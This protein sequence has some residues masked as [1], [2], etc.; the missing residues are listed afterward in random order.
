MNTHPSTLPSWT[1]AY[2]FLNYSFCLGM[3]P[4]VGMLDHMAT[5]LLIFWGT[6]IVFCIP[7]NSVGGFHFSPYPLQNLSVCNDGLSDCSEVVSHCSFY[8]H[9]PNHWASQVVLVEPTCQ[10]RRHKRH[11]FDPWVRK[12]PW[13]RVMLSIV[14]CANWP[15]ICYFW[16]EVCRSFAHFLDWVICFFSCWILWAVCI[17]WKLSP[18]Q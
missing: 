14:S 16:R 17:F 6:S 15:P 13:R 7:T 18:C 11:R 10:C 5:P 9:F 8:L 3:C 2:I 12:I 4:G 1:S